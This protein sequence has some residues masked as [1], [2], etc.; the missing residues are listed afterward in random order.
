VTVQTALDAVDRR[1]LDAVQSGVPLVPRPFAALGE[2]L[3]LREAAVIERL[4]ALRAGGVLRQIG[5]IFDTFRL[6]YR[7][8]LVAARV[9]PARVEEAARLVGE[10][11]G[12]SHCY[13]RDHDWNLWFTLAVPPDSPLGLAGTV[14][15]LAR[16]AGLESARLLPALRVFKIGVRLAMGDGSGEVAP[17]VPESS[18]AGL[19]RT[20]AGRG[21]TARER[22]VV[23][24]LQEPLSLVREPFGGPAQAAGMTVAALLA[25]GEALRAEGFLRRFAAVLHHRRAGYAANVMGVWA[26]PA[27]RVE[28]VGARIATFPAVSHCYE[29]PTSRDWPYS[30]FSM[31]HGRSREECVATLDAIAAATGITEHAAL[32]SLREFKKV[33]LRYFTPDYA[34]WDAR[35]LEGGA[36]AESPGYPVVLRLAGRRVVVIGG[37]AIAERKIEGLLEAGA[38]V[39]VVSPDITR[40][41]EAWAAAGAVALERRRHET[42]DL[43]DAALAYAA[44]DDEAVNRAVVEEAEA[45]GIWLNV[46]DR[47]ER[48]GFFAP[49]VVRRGDLSVAI[50]TN[51]ASPALA[52]RLREK[53]ERQL[54]PEYARALET[55]RAERRRLLR[56]E[57]D[58]ARRRE[59]LEALL[60]ALGLP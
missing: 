34:G 8:C 46:V 9:A 21:L 30:L 13:L 16:E 22:A 11:P 37:G 27:G 33:R 54:G 7:S 52:R 6:G 1:L 3:G 45:K 14:E 32:W 18:A 19:P 56:E 35:A 57:P 44:T 38:R 51:G 50:S 47:P 40:R 49:A 43:S 42:G 23:V 24:A 4:A 55:L 59:A 58:P 2:A 12:V 20:A 39:T 15:H 41:I 25:G 17:A 53:L 29:R 48:C 26:V 31:V 28:E 10:H 5:P 60:D 36:P